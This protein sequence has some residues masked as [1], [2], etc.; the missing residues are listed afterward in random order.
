M[1]VRR[2]LKTGWDIQARR[3]RVVPYPKSIGSGK[4][5]IEKQLEAQVRAFRS[6]DSHTATVL[7]VVRDADELPAAE[8]KALLD[9]TPPSARHVDERIVYVLPK[10]H[11]ETW[12]AYLAGVSVDEDEKREYKN[13][14]GQIAKWKECHP[15]IDQ[16]ASKCREG[17]PLNAPPPSLVEAC[18][19]FERIRDALR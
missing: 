16:L 2:F 4:S 11:I 8:A 5:L 12:L 19:E 13:R 14:Y 18:K 10:W 17:T 6:R 15:L 7:M 3:L 1:F 9:Q